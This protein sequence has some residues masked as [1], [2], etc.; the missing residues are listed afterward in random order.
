[1]PLVDTVLAG[2]LGANV[3]GAAA[4]GGSL[5]VL[6][7]VAVLGLMLSLQPTIATLDGQGRRDLVGPYLRQA[8]LLG[9]GAG[10]LAGA[11]LFAC[12]P[13]VLRAVHA[14]PSLVG[15]AARFLHAVSFSLPA[16]GITFAARG[17]SEGLSRTVPTMVV[18]IAGL[19]VLAPLGATLM[20]GLF[21]LPALGVEGSGIATSVT[22]WAEA[23]L[24][25]AILRRSR[26]YAGVDWTAG[27]WR[28]DPALLVPLVRLGLP[29]ASGL[30]LEAGM[31]SA[32]GLVVA[33]LGPVAAAGNQIA[34]NVVTVSFTVPLSIAM[35]GTVR[36]GNAA[37]Q[38]DAHALRRTVV[39]G[40]MLVAAAGIVSASTLALFARPIAALYGGGPAVTSTAAA[41]LG[42][43]ALFQLSD[44]AQTFAGGILRGLKDTRVPMFIIAGCYWGVGVPLGA[45]LCLCE[46]LGAPGVWMGLFAGLTLAALLLG[47]RL[48]HALRSG[49]PR[50]CATAPA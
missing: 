8:V 13:A 9:A 25:V 24:Y 39:F 47:A 36:A 31:F 18:Q 19:A 22:W 12:G 35:A 49:A 6:G 50:S 34:F 30:L 33:S 4:I 11:A 10:T 43:G 48:R 38:G 44:G 45:W 3:L 27:R 17:L 42:W 21:G 16:V 28:P 1:V 14:T 5:Y 23:A 41:V 26:H 15:P 32:A 20:Y 7:L 40:F 2:H 37:G 29:I 46:Q